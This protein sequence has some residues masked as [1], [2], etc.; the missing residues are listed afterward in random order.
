MAPFSLNLSVTL[1]ETIFGFILGTLL[2]T[3]TSGITL[4]VSDAFQNFRSL[5][6]YFKCNA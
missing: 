6:S 4:V 5:F 2:G 3:I 1:S